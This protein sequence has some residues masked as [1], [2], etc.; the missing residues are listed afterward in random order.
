MMNRITFLKC[1]EAKLDRDIA[2]TRKRT[3]ELLSRKAERTKDDDVLKATQ[4]VL[5]TIK[6]TSGG[7]GCAW[8]HAC[9]WLCAQQ[10]CQLQLFCPYV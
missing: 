8:V 7:G 4:D 3:E 1:E 2:N 6:G 9:R 5:S 10:A